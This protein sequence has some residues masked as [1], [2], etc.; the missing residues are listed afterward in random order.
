MKA[1]GI[2][3]ALVFWTAP[4]LAALPEACG[5]E[6]VAAEGSSLAPIPCCA[7]EAHTCCFELSVSPGDLLLLAERAPE[8]RVEW[9]PTHCF[10]LSELPVPKVSSLEESHA[11]SSRAPPGAGV[12]IRRHYQVWLI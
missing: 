2:L 10:G 8:N 11:I 6:H 3:L 7:A 4:L 1:S 5:C 9:K 12:D